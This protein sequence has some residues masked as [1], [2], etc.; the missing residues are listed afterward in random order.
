MFFKQI[1]PN[2]SWFGEDKIVTM[3]PFG[4]DLVVSLFSGTTACNY[5]I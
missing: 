1:G 2:P 4:E 3:D 5:K